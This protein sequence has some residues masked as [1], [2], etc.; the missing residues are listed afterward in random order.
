MA[1]QYDAE[2]TKSSVGKMYV[3]SPILIGAAIYSAWLAKEAR[4]TH[5]EISLGQGTPN[6]PWWEGYAWSIGFVVAAIV[7]VWA[8]RI[9]GR[10]L[11]AQEQ[12]QRE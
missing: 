10:R 11:R 1:Y 9:A 8:A 4:R 5:T 12:R 7:V 3:L 2:L 6:V